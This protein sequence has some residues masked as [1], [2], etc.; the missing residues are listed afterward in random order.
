MIRNLAGKSSTR[1]PLQSFSAHELLH[2][3]LAGLHFRNDLTHNGEHRNAS[4]VDLLFAN[5]LKL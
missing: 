4:I 2:R 1:I 5:Q 3:A